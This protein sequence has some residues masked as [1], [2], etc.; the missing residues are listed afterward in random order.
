MGNFTHIWGGDSEENCL[1][2]P[3]KDVKYVP[4][5]WSW[6]LLVW[7]GV[8]WGRPGVILE[9]RIRVFNTRLIGVSKITTEYSI[10]LCLLGC[11]TRFYPES[12]RIFQIPNRDIQSTNTS[13][14]YEHWTSTTLTF[15]KCLSI[16]WTEWWVNPR[17]SKSMSPW[18]SWYNVK[19]IKVGSPVHL[20]RLY[21]SCS[22][23]F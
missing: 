13:A 19:N 16:K 10:R 5:A 11:C 21:F 6:E 23:C 17:L 3:S 8:V 18:S 9:C 14:K 15:V 7:S 2:R 20:H 12:I 22:S 1:A 4:N